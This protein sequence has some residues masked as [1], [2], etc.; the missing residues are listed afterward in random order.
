M[1]SIGKINP[2]FTS[3]SNELTVAAAAFNLDFSLIKFEA[4][5]EFH[6]VRDALS[7]SRRSNAEDGMAHIT[8]RKLGALFESIFPPIPHL[9]EAYGKRASEI[10]S[11]ADSAKSKGAE[12]GIFAKQAGF[13]GTSI[14]AAATSG[15]GAIAIHLLACMLARI[16]AAPEAISLWVELVERRKQEITSH[17]QNGNVTELAN[18]MAARQDITREQ[19][20]TWDASARSWLLTADKAKELQQIQ[21]MIIL[22]NIRVPVNTNNDAFDGVIE[23]L[24][25]ALTAMDRLVQGIP[26]RITNGATLLA[27]SSWHLYPDIHILASEVKSIS[28][29]DKLMV[30]AT[31]TLSAVNSD[32]SQAG[33][34][35]SLP[36]SRMRYYSPPMMVERQV[37]S[38]TSHV[39]LAEF[40]IVCLGAILAPWLETGADEDRCCRLIITISEKIDRFEAGLRWFE[41]LNKAAKDYIASQGTLRQRHRQL[42]AL[43]L[44]R[45]GNFLNYSSGGCI[46]FFGL[47]F[48]S[49]LFSLLSHEES[50]I[51]ILRGIA[52]PLRISPDDVIIR[53]Q[54]KGPNDAGVF[55][56][57]S[58]KEMRRSGQKRTVEGISRSSERHHRWVIGR[59]KK[60]DIV[61]KKKAKRSHKTIPITFPRTFDWD[62]HDSLYQ[63]SLPL[64]GRPCDD[65][66]SDCN[67]CYICTTFPDEK[68]PNCICN[69]SC[70]SCYNDKVKRRMA[71]QNEDWSFIKEN[72]AYGTDSHGFILRKHAEYEQSFEFVSGD[73]STCA[74][75]RARS[76]GVFQSEEP[77]ESPLATIGQIEDVIQSS[78]LNVDVLISYL[79]R[80]S[81]PWPDHSAFLLA[82][83]QLDHLYQNL[84]GARINLKILQSQLYNAK[85]VEEGTS[86]MEKLTSMFACI[87]MMESGEFDIVPSSL[88]NVIAL[89]SGDSIFVVSALLQDPVQIATSSQPIK[90]VSGSVG[91]SELVFMVPTAEPAL[92]T[93]DPGAWC[94]INHHPFDGQFLNAFIG[95]SLH[96]SFTDFE[97]PLDVGSRGLRDRQ[98]IILESVISLNDGGAH[99][100]DLD[101]TSALTA[102]RASIV[103]Y[104][105]CDE[106][107]E[108]SWNYGRIDQL[109]FEY[110]DH[111]LGNNKQNV[112][113]SERAEVQA[114]YKDNIISLDCW[115][116]FFDSPLK[117]AG[118]FRAAGNWEARLAAV[119]AS[120]Q[121]RKRVLILPPNACIFC[122]EEYRDRAKFDVIIA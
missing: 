7:V 74:L 70:P 30:G 61:K 92:K 71:E 120:K 63:N 90:R 82:L 22:K 67:R 42:L 112:T 54:R 29:G 48:F 122:L 35:W 37:A 10:S 77:Q 26:Q 18:V 32:E 31:L 100:G 53:Y 15:N 78:A 1:A 115:E 96:L 34:F 119:A 50:A 3:L 33:V 84:E 101:I 106:S 107:F 24:T 41:V 91:R 108:N 49:N 89:S 38:H 117:G 99:Y 21:L 23:A 104:K 52:S 97:F 16:W 43:G 113:A 83:S 58:A 98:A 6:G 2:A 118:I 81:Y 4:P 68:I 121:L 11:S 25:T 45:T 111:D 69:A 56:Y 64:N 57:C 102:L 8:A 109:A 60:D 114:E 85:W 36:L 40:R 51:S 76:P 59:T 47:K 88:E 94:L 105:E 75:F 66:E 62:Q 80:W 28:Q 14:W 79:Q 46:P 55:E 19:L 110:C 12:Y 72:D 39:S 86:R 44:R 103:E 5:K 116:E 13:D 17:L 93:A 27:I 9:I 65:E 73:V 95:T 20:A 87:A